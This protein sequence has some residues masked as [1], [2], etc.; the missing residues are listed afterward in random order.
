MFMLFFVSF[1]ALNMGDDPNSQAPL[2]SWL[3][4]SP[5]GP[6]LAVIRKANLMFQCIILSNA[7]LFSIV[8]F[9]CGIHKLNYIKNDF[10]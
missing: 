7:T 1:L 10:V 9:A 3:P 6:K 2:V 4:V 8:F 5:S